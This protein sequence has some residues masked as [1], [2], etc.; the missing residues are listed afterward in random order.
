MCYNSIMKT[1]RNADF[2][3]KVAASARI[4]GYHKRQVEAAKATGDPEAE[5]RAIINAESEWIELVTK[6]M[7]L[8]F[9]VRGREIIPDRGC[10][11]I[12]NHQSYFDVMALLTALKGHQFSFIAKD[13]FDKV[14]LLSAWVLRSRG[15]FIHRGDARES[16][17]TIQKGAEYV[18]DGFSIVIFPEGTR[19]RGPEM[20]EFKPGSFKLATK[21]KAPVVPITIDGT[22]RYFEED[23]FR[24]GQRAIVTI[25]PPIETEGMSRT[26]QAELHDRVWN[27]IHDE[28]GKA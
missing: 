16:L 21:A 11:Y 18:K 24:K 1:F 23:G 13:D 17:K 12:A 2:L 25:H 9:D 4:Q 8:R 22:Y 27:I 15:L 3:L 6:S 10:V 5:R 20:A 14:P 7:D 28:L 26:E 19:S